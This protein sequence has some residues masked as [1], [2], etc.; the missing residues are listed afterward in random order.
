MYAVQMKLTVILDDVTLTLWI[1]MLSFLLTGMLL[2][3]MMLTTSTM[4]MKEG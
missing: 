2:M 4:M 1:S 3:A